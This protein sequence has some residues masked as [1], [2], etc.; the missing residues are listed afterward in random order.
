MNEMKFISSSAK[1][2]VDYLKFLV[3]LTFIF[4]HGDDSKQ[5]KIKRGK[6]NLILLIVFPSSTQTFT[7][8]TMKPEIRKDKRNKTEHRF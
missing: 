3:L 4:E 6:N 7:Y 5:K 8:P 2:F 1:P